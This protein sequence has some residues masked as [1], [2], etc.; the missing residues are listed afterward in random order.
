MYSKWTSPWTL[1]YILGSKI[2]NISLATN[3]QS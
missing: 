3:L 1:V 2:G